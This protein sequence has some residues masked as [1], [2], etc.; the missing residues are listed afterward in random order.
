MEKRRGLGKTVLDELTHV[1]QHPAYH[2]RQPPCVSMGFLALLFTLRNRLVGAARSVLLLSIPGL[3]E[4]VF[5][6]SYCQELTQA[7]SLL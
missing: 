5:T 1:S 3:P 4:D 2:S 7:R 6:P